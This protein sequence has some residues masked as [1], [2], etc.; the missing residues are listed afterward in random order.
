MSIER[1]CRAHPEHERDDDAEV[2]D[3]DRRRGAL[4]EMADV[5]LEADAEHE[6]D[7]ADLTQQLQDVERRFWKE[8]RVAGR[9][10]LAD[11][12][13]PEH[14]SRGDLADDGRLPGE[15]REATAHLRRQD[16]DE[17]LD[18][19]ERERP[20]QGVS[21]REG[22]LRRVAHDGHAR[23]REPGLAQ[24]QQAGDQGN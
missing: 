5:E 6:Q 2:A 16:D 17:Q 11:E 20:A 23:R 10:Q 9:P 14:E 4:A 7:D 13:R 21:S 8:E 22:R 18:D 3:G 1:Q 19:E 24:V 12:R 15:R